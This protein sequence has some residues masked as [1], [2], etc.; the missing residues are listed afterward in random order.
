MWVV[1]SQ[2]RDETLNIAAQK[3]AHCVRFEWDGRYPKKRQ[4]CLDTLNLK[5]D[6][7][8][9]VDADERVPQALIDEIAALDFRCAGYF[10]KGQYEFEGRALRFGL[11]NHKIALMDRTRMEFPI[12]DDLDIAGM[13]EIEGHYQP[14][15]KPDCASGIIGR[16]KTPLTHK[17]YDDQKKW[18]AR[19]MRYAQWEAAMT[20]KKRWPPEPRVVRGM[21]K[22]LFR[23]LPFT[24]Y[25]AFAH[26]YILKLGFLDG[27]RGYRFACSRA[28]YYRMILNASKAPE[29]TSAHATV[30]P[31]R[32]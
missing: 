11:Q 13:G 19:H 14:V 28:R 10:V 1:D 9:F 20:Q 7:V 29:T 22:M 15:L 30:K 17:A 5:Y 21:L 12:V 18:E 26:S 32:L 6:R 8:L 3:G 24:P 23:A 31:E 2:S 27:V 16:L 25:I 4:W